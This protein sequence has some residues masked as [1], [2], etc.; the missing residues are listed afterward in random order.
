[1]GRE[2]VCTLATT[3]SPACSSAWALTTPI[4]PGHLHHV[5]LV[6]RL[7]DEF[8]AV[9]QD[10]RALLH[11]GDEVGKDDGLAGTGGQSEEL[12]PDATQICSGDGI[13]GLVLVGTQ[14]Q[15]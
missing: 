13:E 11:L 7:P 10:E 6:E 12:T 2:R 5:E 4:E 15:G 3:T 8:V 14:G 1:M 9:H